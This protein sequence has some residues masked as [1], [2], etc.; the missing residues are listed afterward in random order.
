MSDRLSILERYVKRRDEAHKKSFKEVLEEFEN[1]RYTVKELIV[2]NKFMKKHNIPSYDFSSI[3]HTQTVSFR[4]D[5]N[6]NFFVM[7][8]N[9]PW[10]MPLSLY[11]DDNGQYNFAEGSGFKKIVNKETELEFLKAFNQYYPQVRDDFY[12]HIDS[13]EQKMFN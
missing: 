12:K 13:F 9:K 10:A 11:I 6:N 7:K 5:D 3:Q 2:L 4:F 8:L 1:H